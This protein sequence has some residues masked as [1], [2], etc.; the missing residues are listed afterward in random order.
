MMFGIKIQGSNRSKSG[1][2]VLSFDLRHILTLI[3][4]PILA[5]SWRCRDLRYI[6]EIDGAFDEIREAGRKLSGEEMMQ[7][8]AR[9][10][11]TIDGRFEARSGGS[12]KKPWLVI[13]AVDSSWFEVWS[14][15]RDVIER[16]KAGF[17]NVNDLPKGA[18]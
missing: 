8:A 7:F 3:G 10:H 16:V 6:A 2:R 14:S 4:E 13:L 12:A 17:D 11:Q 5:S 15:K 1:G 18:A 9:L